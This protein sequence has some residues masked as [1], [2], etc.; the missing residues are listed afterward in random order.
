MADNQTN[1]STS[2]AE[3]TMMRLADSIE[4][5]VATSLTNLPI[6]QFGGNPN[7]DIFEFLT[8]Y[9][10][11][12]ISVG[13]AMRCKALQRALTG[14][15]YVWARN[16]IKKNITEGKNWKA[17]KAALI[18]RFQP[19]NA[20]MRFHE[21]LSKMKYDQDK[22]SLLSYVEAYA[23][24]Y[25]RVHHEAKDKDIISQLKLNL[26]NRI[27]RA[28]NVINDGWSNLDDLKEVFKLARRAE[29]KILPFDKDENQNQLNASS[30]IEILNSFKNSIREEVAKQATNKE[31][32][33]AAIQLAG[34]QTNTNRATRN[35]EFASNQAQ[36]A[37]RGGYQRIRRPDNRDQGKRGYAPYPN[38]APG[39]RSY[40]PQ[41]EAQKLK[42]AYNAKNGAPPR[43]CH[44]CGGH[45]WNHDCPL[46]K[47]EEAEAL[48]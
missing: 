47:S 35:D 16:N 24:C 21:K 11:A 30:L 38:R 1:T 29:E 25:R 19:P 45:H 15:A 42:D 22:D 17:C 18:E 20:E 28:L 8:K 32:A 31:E 13:E 26:P 33:L 36:N 9:K 14:A 7:E 3:M 27:Q 2:A 48:K 4:Q 46:L 44:A 34:Q 12:T 6:P 23:D 37:S 10:A 40:I 5:Q 43:P 39:R 41:E